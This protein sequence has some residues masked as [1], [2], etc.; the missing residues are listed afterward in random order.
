MAH[1]VAFSPPTW[2]DVDAEM[3][4]ETRWQ[5]HAEADKAWKDTHELVYNHQLHYGGQLVALF[6]DTERTLQ[7]KWGEIWEC[8]HQLAD[9]E[10]VS[11]NTCLGLALQVLNKLPIIPIDLAFSMQIPIV[12]GY[13][14]ESCIFQT[15]CT[16]QGGTSPLK[17]KF[18]AS[19]ILSKKLK[20]AAHEG[21][22]DDSSPER[23]PSP[24][25]SVAGGCLWTQSCSQ[26][27][28]P[29]TA[30]VH[31]CPAQGRACTCTFPRKPTHRSPP[32]V[33]MIRAP[34]QMR[35]KMTWVMR[36]PTRTTMA[37]MKRRQT[38]TVRKVTKRTP[39]PRRTKQVAKHVM[40]I[41][42]EQWQLL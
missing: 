29:S 35:A 10:G 27:K 31:L 21:E 24:T 33:R 40:R 7:E 15:W 8:I 42:Q 14:P 36:T 3:L 26:S 13:C 41:W 17:E 4:E 37:L 19:H 6:W 16:D 22:M 5:I 11:L 1:N 23:T 12:M 30:V 38:Q 18:K 9:V 39:L 25:H 20:W 28:S 34:M 32:R 2:V